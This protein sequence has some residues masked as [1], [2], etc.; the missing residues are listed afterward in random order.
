[1]VFMEDV[2]L[3]GAGRRCNAGFGLCGRL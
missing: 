2:Y 3:Y 1:K